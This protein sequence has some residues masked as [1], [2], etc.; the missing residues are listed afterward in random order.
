MRCSCG[1]LD[2]LHLQRERLSVIHQSRATYPF[3]DSRRWRPRFSPAGDRRSELA[4]TSKPTTYSR[5][6]MPARG[7]DERAR[8]EQAEQ[9]AEAGPPLDADHP[10]AGHAVARK[11][12]LF[13]RDDAAHV[14][15]TFHHAA[16]GA[17]ALVFSSGGRP[18]VRKLCRSTP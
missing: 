7:C 12:W 11:N 14:N 2:G 17:R 5:S 4:A 1:Y 3:G 16:G 6:P 10:A 8:P 15:A 18:S 13:G 9:L